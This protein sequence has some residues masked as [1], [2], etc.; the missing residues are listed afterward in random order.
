[1]ASK[2]AS[3]FSRRPQGG[4]HEALFQ[5]FL[6]LRGQEIGFYV[7]MQKGLAALLE[8][9]YWVLVSL[10]CAWHFRIHRKSM[11]FIGMVFVF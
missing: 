7:L 8:L 9:A 3:I 11:E 6:R 10:H 1:M 4:N 5:I 2:S